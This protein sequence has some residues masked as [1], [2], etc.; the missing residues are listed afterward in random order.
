MVFHQYVYHCMFALTK[1]YL[2]MHKPNSKKTFFK[3]VPALNSLSY[4]MDKTP[5]ERTVT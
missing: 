5:F 3:E 2:Q 1:V 4:S